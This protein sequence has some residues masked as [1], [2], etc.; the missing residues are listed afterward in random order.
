M[1]EL[2]PVVPSALDTYKLSISKQ[3][4]FMMHIEKHGALYLGG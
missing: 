3:Q 4:V 2:T 1:G